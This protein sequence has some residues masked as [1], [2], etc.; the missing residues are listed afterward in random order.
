[1]GAAIGTWLLP[2]L[3]VH[4]GIRVTMLI[5]GVICLIGT[6]VSQVMAPETTGQTLSRINRSTLTNPGTRS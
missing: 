2:V 6:L 1:V 3:V 4:L 5:F